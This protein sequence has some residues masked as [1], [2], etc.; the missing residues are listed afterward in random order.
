MVVFPHDE[1]LSLIVSLVG[2]FPARITAWILIGIWF[3]TQ[4]IS[5][6]GSITSVDQGGVAYFAHIGGFIG[7]AL[8]VK[9]FVI[10]HPP[11]QAE[12]SQEEGAA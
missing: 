10:G 7:G 1:I 2:I 6:V 11:S 9:P 4:L 12:R 5:G 3:L 8:L